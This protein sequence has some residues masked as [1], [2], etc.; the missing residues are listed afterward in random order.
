MTTSNAFHSFRT[1]LVK[2]YLGGAAGVALD[3]AEHVLVL[4]PGAGGASGLW[5]VND[6]ASAKCKEVR[7]ACSGI[8]SFSFSLKKWV[9]MITDL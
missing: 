2:A 6:A 7:G 5:C 3:V 1:S 9:R 8:C 4:V